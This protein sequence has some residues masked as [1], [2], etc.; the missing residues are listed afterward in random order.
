ME[1]EAGDVGSYPTLTLIPIQGPPVFSLCCHKDKAAAIDWERW[2]LGAVG[3]GLAGCLSPGRL[4]VSVDGCICS[5]SPF[6]PACSGK[7]KAH[8]GA[9]V[10]YRKARIGNGNTN[11]WLASETGLGRPRDLSVPNSA[12]LPPSAAFSVTCFKA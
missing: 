9:L 11:T 4:C 1:V 8:G 5:S 10:I 7:G 2:E 3:T 6:R 12:L